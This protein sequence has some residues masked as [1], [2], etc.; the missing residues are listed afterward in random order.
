[1]KKIFIWYAWTIWC[2]KSPITNYL[3]TKLW[4]PTF[5]T[6]AIRSEV[7]EDLLQVNEDVAQKRIKERLNDIIQNWTSFIYDA[8]VDRR[9]ELIKEI[10]LKNDYNYF[11]ISIDLNKETLLKFYEAKSYFESI[12]KLEK[13]YDDHQKFLEKYWNEIN[14]HIDNKNYSERLEIVYEAAKHRINKQK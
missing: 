8:S 12:E 9:R 5:N 2:W 13:V 4:L 11:L 1:M 6:D 3:S 7:C 14:I 10:L